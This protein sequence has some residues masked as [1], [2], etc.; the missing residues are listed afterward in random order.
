MKRLALIVVVLSVFASIA[1]GA[2]CGKCRGKMY[3]M[4]V[5][6]CTQCAGH[7]SSGAHKLCRK[8]STKLGQCEHCR[9]PLG[10]TG[11][12]IGP[13][14][15]PAESPAP[16]DG[17]VLTEAQS[18][19]KTQVG[20]GSMF[21]VKL[22]V[23]PIM[24]W[25][26]DP[27]DGGVLV[28]DGKPKHLPL[29]GPDGRPLP[30]FAPAGHMLYTFRAIKLGSQTLTFKLIPRTNSP[31]RNTKTVAL[32]IE[33]TRDAPAPKPAPGAEKGQASPPV[34]KDG[35]SLS[36]APA[37]AVFPMKEPIALDVTFK[38]VSDK[39]I[40]LAGSRF[41]R[42]QPMG[43]FTF[44]VK[45]TKSGKTYTLREGSN[46]MIMAPVRMENKTIQPGASLEVKAIIDQWARGEG[47]KPAPN[48]PPLRRGPIRLGGPAI[49]GAKAAGR[50]VLGPDLLPGGTYEAIVQAKFGKGF[51]KDVTFWVGQID[52]KP[53]TFEIDPTKTAP[54][55]GGRAGAGGVEGKWVTLYADEPWYKRRKGAESTVTGIL[56][57]VPNAGG[58][59]TLM[60][61][62]HYTIGKYRLYTGAKKHP[63]LDKLA[64]KAVQLRG[65]LVS[66][67]L[68]GRELQEIWPAAVRQTKGPVVGTGTG[69]VSQPLRK[70]VPVPLPRQIHVEDR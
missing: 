45:E 10:P 19:E 66:M 69:K 6:K 34:V 17:V 38:N 48:A 61:T 16:T 23:D 11:P 41:M 12:V 15:G 56:Q 22:K 28:Q 32:T 40:V 49:G 62:A 43:G 9:A 54:G 55:A 27:I 13:V 65:K 37:K 63:E 29:L 2:L 47:L 20:V 64:G 7:T 35:L 5:G 68:E 3:I 18:G 51:G 42:W 52:A 59:T 39:P 67:A 50:G 24:Q 60:R 8:C 44:Q 14:R 31:K 33:V 53:V 36:V 46:P 25:G 1:P 21:Y 70:I 58:A 4:S 26:L 57:G 30:T